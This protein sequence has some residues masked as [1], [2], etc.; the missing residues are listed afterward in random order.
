[1]SKPSKQFKTSSWRESSDSKLISPRNFQIYESCC[2]CEIDHSVYWYQLLHHCGRALY[3]SYSDCDTKS[4]NCIHAPAKLSTLSSHGSGLQQS[5]VQLQHEEYP[6][7]SKRWICPAANPQCGEVCQKSQ[8][9]S[10]MFPKAPHRAKGDI[11]ISI[12]QA[13]RICSG[14]ETLGAEVNGHDQ[15]HWVSK[16]QWWVP[17]ET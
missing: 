5:S 12:T 3:M 17:R 13:P 11:W 2:E 6:N 4:Y 14:P 7:S 15:R 10:K 16:L 9:E 1:M 8:V